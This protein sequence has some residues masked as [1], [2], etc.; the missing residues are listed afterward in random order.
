MDVYWI[1]FLLVGALAGVLTLP[2][3]TDHPAVHVLAWVSFWPFLV[4]HLCWFGL[5]AY[6]K[7]WWQYRDRKE[8]ARIARERATEDADSPFR[9][10]TAGRTIRETY[11]KMLRRSGTSEPP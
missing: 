4:A 5:L 8:A 7:K 2:W 1:V 10:C 6:R 11:T 9:H 3:S